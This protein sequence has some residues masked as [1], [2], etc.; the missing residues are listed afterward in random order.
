MFGITVYSTNVGVY[1]SGAGYHYLAL[2]GDFFISVLFHHDYYH[3]YWGVLCQW[4]F[5]LN[6]VFRLSETR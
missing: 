2:F 5:L 6:Q 4:L 1:S 3:C